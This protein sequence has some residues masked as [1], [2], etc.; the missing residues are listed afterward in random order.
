MAYGGV[1]EWSLEELEAELRRLREVEAARDLDHRE[2]APE[3]VSWRVTRAVLEMLDAHAGP[4][5]VDRRLRAAGLAPS[6]VRGRRTWWTWPGYCEVADALEPLVDGGAVREGMR[7]LLGSPALQFLRVAITPFAPLALVLQGMGRLVAGPGGVLLRGFTLEVRRAGPTR[8]EARFEPP[9]GPE[10]PALFVEATRSFLE[11]LPGTTDAGAREI[12]VRRDGRAVTFAVRYA[13]PSGAARARA[14]IGQ[15]LPRIEARAVRDAEQELSGRNEELRQ[16]ILELEAS[17]RA[18]AALQA[19]LVEQER[20][21]AVG[22]FAGGVAHDFNN[23]LTVVL[24]QVALLEPR[25]EASM[26]AD[27]GMVEEASRRAASLCRQL[28]AVGRQQ[29]MEIELVDLK[30]LVEER[31]ELFDAAAGEPVALRFALEE[32]G[33]VK[34][35]G[36]SLERVILD[37]IDNARAALP[38]GGALE[39]RA[40]RVE[41]GDEEATSYP[42][43]DSGS[44]A[45]LTVRDEGHGMEPEV[46]ARALEPVVT[47]HRDRG[48]RGLGLSSAFG[49]V[50]Q[51]GGAL[52]LR[53]A[54]GEGTEVRILLPQ[55]EPA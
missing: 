36:A 7:G 39:V 47:T 54:P 26:K 14:L 24:S 37:L 25:L 23:L 8:V 40:G 35:D 30:A 6:T 49:V 9:P 11:G 34:A 43:A 46:R 31:R 42:G 13:Q 18:R 29:P 19:E 1:E 45:M 20:M 50:R 12:S 2:E 53:S 55:A 10:L 22:R 4:D 33:R 27:L 5:E 48:A 16:R 17:E 3:E 51:L 41:V 52:W 15:L 21:E 44:Y 32:T 38:E 28:L